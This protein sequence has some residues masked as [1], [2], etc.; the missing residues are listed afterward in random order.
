MI[1]SQHVAAALLTGALVLAGGAAQAAS[2]SETDPS[3]DAA[4]AVDITRVTVTNSTKT[5]TVMVKVK[6]ATAGR[7][8]VV[9]TITPAAEGASTYVARTVDTGQGHRVGGTLEA[10]APG[11]TDATPVD[12][13]GLKAAVSS[14]RNGMVHLR[15]PQSCF[16]ADAGDAT[17]A[18]VTETGSG[19]TADSLPDDLSVDQG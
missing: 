11:A 1:R 18:V 13:P 16:G 3:G 4:P 9:A 15:I 17:V 2:Q 8:H 6:R 12:C 7:S 19:D 14:G 10:T 5:L